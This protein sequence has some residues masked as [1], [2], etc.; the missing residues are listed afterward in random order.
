MPGI[1][2]V[3]TDRGIENCVCSIKA[4]NFEMYEY[5]I[6]GARCVVFFTLWDPVYPLGALTISYLQLISVVHSEG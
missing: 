5:Y 2:F 3:H 6:K 4:P 1:T